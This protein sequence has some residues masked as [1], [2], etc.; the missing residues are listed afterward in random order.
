MNPTL[1]RGIPSSLS[2]GEK[3]A[4]LQISGLGQQRHLR[5]RD[6]WIYTY[7]RFY[8]TVSPP[9]VFRILCTKTFPFRSTET[10]N[11]EFFPL[12]HLTQKVYFDTET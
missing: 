4:D 10:V 2:Y 12:Q 11:R 7:I 9:C 8:C 1:K 3:F 6:F 5:I